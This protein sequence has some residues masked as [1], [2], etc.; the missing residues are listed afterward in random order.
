MHDCA[1]TATV[2]APLDLVISVDTSVD[3]LG[4]ALGKPV[5]MLLPFCPDWRGLLDRSDS[6]WYPTMRLFRQAKPGDW[7][8]VFAQVKAALTVPGEL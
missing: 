4:G 5:W 7:Q 8:T 2:N 1:D 3:H 6:P